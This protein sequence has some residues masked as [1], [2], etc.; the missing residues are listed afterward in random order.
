MVFIPGSSLRGEGQDNGRCSVGGAGSGEMH[1]WKVPRTLKS[2]N[3]GHAVQD[4]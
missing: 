4:R 1:S 2:R 3:S